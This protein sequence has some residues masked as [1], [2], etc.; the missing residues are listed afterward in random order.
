VV[1]VEGYELA[2]LRGARRVLTAAG[3]RP[4][5]IVEMHP[6]V[7]PG[8]GESRHTAERLL[9]ELG[10]TAIPLTGQSDPLS[11][12]GNVALEPA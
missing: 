11:D 5:V 2:V 1:D 9:R 4:G 10:L 7:W 12:H 6:D 3:A 8:L